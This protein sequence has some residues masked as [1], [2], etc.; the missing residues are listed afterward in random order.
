MYQLNVLLCSKS[1]IKKKV[2]TDF[3]SQRYINF[4]TDIECIDCS[5]CGLPPQPINCGIECATERIKYAKKILQKKDQLFLF[6]SIENDLA[7]DGYLIG[8]RDDEYYDRAHVRMEFAN[9]IGYGVSEKILCPLQEKQYQ[10]QSQKTVVY[11]NRISGY[12]KT[13]GEFMEEMYGVNADNW[14]ADLSHTDRKWQI[15]HA[16]ELAFEDL[17]NSICSCK[18]ISDS[19]KTYPNFPKT[20]VNFKYFYSLFQNENMSKLTSLLHKK[21]NCTQF[22][23]ILP[24]ES[25]GLVL[26]A[27]L[28]NILK[29]SMIPLQKPGKIPGISLDMAYEKEYGK[30]EIQVSVD[31]FDNLFENK[32][33]L[34]RFLIVDDLIAT[35]GTIEASVK[36]LKILSEKYGFNFEVEILALDEVEPLRENAEKKIGNDYTIMFRDIDKCWDFILNMH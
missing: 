5:G 26:G 36:I 12:A 7:Y 19:Y 1:E 31:L 2:V 14:M 15:E 25:R 8:R 17:C 27:L 22:D 11:S 6:I 9:C 20:G 34:Y 35:G 23:A 13:G 28:A 18:I 16:L 30:D 29:T 24:L 33:S 10:F 21:Y 3:F 4:T 32:K